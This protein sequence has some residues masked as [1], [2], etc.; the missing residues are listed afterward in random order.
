MSYHKQWV[1][2]NENRNTNKDFFEIIMKQRIK[3]GFYFLNR[4]CSTNKFLFIKALPAYKA[5][6]SKTSEK[7]QTNKLNMSFKKENAL[8]KQGKLLL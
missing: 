5:K 2:K 4:G 8:N 7:S 3:E 1:W 6:L